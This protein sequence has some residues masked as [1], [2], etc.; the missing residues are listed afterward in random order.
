MDIN[1]GINPKQSKQKGQGNLWL[2]G[3]TTTSPTNLRCPPEHLLIPIRSG[4][5][6]FGS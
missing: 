2:P 6:L 3:S 5:T 1:P 4:D